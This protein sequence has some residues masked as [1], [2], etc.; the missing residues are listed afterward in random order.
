MTR[1]DATLWAALD[2]EL[3]LWAAGGR[4]A[5]FWLRDDDAIEPTAA[6]DRL[7]D[8]TAATET[9]LALAV[10]PA[11]ASAGLARRLAAAKDASVLQHGYAHA[12][13]AAAGEKKSEFAERRP[14][15]EMTGEIV[16]GRAALL[17]LFGEAAL[18]VLAPPWN[19][20]SPG[21]VARLGACGLTGLSRFTS[22]KAPEAAP[23]VV[24]ANTHVDLI[25]WRGGRT[26]KP[27]QTVLQEIAVTLRDRREGRADRDEP[28]GLLTH[29]L[30]MDAAAWSALEA[31][32]A[33]L[34]RDSRATWLGAPAIFGA[35][36]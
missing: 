9:P 1:A 10:I 28:T 26:G 35:A 23:G 11:G 17:R 2:A 3:D 16:R 25:D 18:P 20:I 6:L 5:T 8:L 15:P 32:L 19:R 4:P 27:V 13:H 21:V 14:L 31:T 22:R 30:V 33:R 34:G 36:A 12:N 7:F 24:E 29:H